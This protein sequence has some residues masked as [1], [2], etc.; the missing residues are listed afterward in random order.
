M[1]K[2]N[3]EDLNEL[4]Y[5]MAAKL[6][7]EMAAK[8]TAKMK[9]DF[10]SQCN[11]LQKDIECKAKEIEKLKCSKDVAVLEQL[12]DIHRAGNKWV[13]EFDESPVK[14]ADGLPDYLNK[15]YQAIK[16]CPD[17]DQI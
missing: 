16:N 8:E 12:K 2:M 11:W 4:V 9:A 13:K 3:A 17:V 10:Q 7:K 15:L 6:A 14:P 1:I 5:S